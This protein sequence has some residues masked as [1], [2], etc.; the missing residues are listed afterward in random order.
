MRGLKSEICWEGQ[1]FW[2]HG[3]YRELNERA[4]L[5]DGS[6]PEEEAAC[7]PHVYR[8]IR[9]AFNGPE[10]CGAIPEGTESAPGCPAGCP[11]E[12][13]EAPGGPVTVYIAPGVYWIDDPGATDLMRK[14]PGDLLPF[15]MQIRCG[16][17]NIEG[18]SGHSE[19]VVIAGNRGQSH[20][21]NGNYTMLHFQVEELC[22]S[23][24]TLGNY[25][26]VDLVYPLDPSL[27]YPKR[28]DTIT[29]AQL[30]IQQG[31]K[32]YAR[33]CRF[34]SRLNLSP[35]CG[36]ERALYESC[37]FESTDDALN[38]NAVY[39]G[40]DFDF[41][42]GRPIY[43]ARQTGDVFIDCL[44][45]SRLAGGDAE[46][47]QYLTKE[48]GPVALI[49]C[50]YESGEGVRLYWTKYPGTALKC[51]QYQVSQNGQPV[52]L[53]GEEAEETV[54][55]Q[56]KKALE[57]YILEQ[58]GRYSANVG[59]LLGGSDG[60]DPMGL[61]AWAESAGRVGIPTLLTL[62]AQPSVIS[63]GEEAVLSAQA[64][65]FSHEPCGDYEPC[66]NREPC[67][68]KARFSVSA[69]D[70]AY[71]T[72]RQEGDASCVVTGCNHG[73]EAR[74]VV[75]R[76]CTENGLEAAVAVTVEP[77][78]QPAP[79][80]LK[81]PC[82]RRDNG[83]LILEYELSSG[84]ADISD[85]S[86]YRCDSPEGGGAVLCGIS[87]RDRPLGAYRLTAADEGGYMK[88]VIRPRVK[89]S[90]EGEAADAFL[91][92]PVEE[93]EVDRNRLFTD[94]SELPDG[95]R[96]TAQ[97]GRWI[98]DRAKPED[99]E[100]DSENF[101]GWAADTGAPAWRYG[102]TGNG[103]V[104]EG[105][106]QGVQ[107]A[108]LR[109]TPV[110]EHSGGMSMTVKA[111]PAKTAG[112][113][114]GIAGQYMDFGIKFDTVR[115]TGYALRVIRVREASDAVAMALVEYRDGRSRYLT[116]RIL[117][118]CYLTGCTIR[119]SLEG[120]RLTAEAST[121]APQPACKLEKGYEQAVRLEAEVEK[122][123]YGGILFWHT[124]TP[125]TGGWQNTTMLHSVEAIYDSV[126]S[127][128]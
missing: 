60:W 79:A 108:R 38:G 110:R 33:D 82:I 100:P 122:N 121:T 83:K 86:W 54:Q 42:G 1:G 58:D 97:G 14:K 22:V 76:A 95:S 53:G 15:G 126:V 111:D 78:L 65:L 92:E 101:S 47:C 118:S 30:A 69:E 35:I 55:L 59:N 43:R 67:E 40:C 87:R 113:G 18:L 102:R 74:E 51:Y 68:E 89:G 52:T 48:G 66:G 125:G 120:K 88:A 56:G 32:L 10:V 7:R 34:V 26:S 23:G 41:Y 21:C 45:R 107:G 29:Q 11:Q 117:T 20:A 73:T 17:L 4:V 39:V 90:L 50:R 77:Y 6:L 37:H 93:G 123:P 25:C 8:E 36:A 75:I 28:T 3:R 96:E 106:Y 127:G 2:Y 49:G 57:A 80:F 44:F 31:E 98:F 71:V 84:E 12:D 81:A 105:L 63:F 94:F 9:Q 115:L 116:E 5:L 103:S 85:I 124:G 72:I 61:L 104:G 109:Y 13:C 119:V 70:G 46:S 99:L 16:A 128:N 64:F 24:I 62:T 27:N 91:A 114:F 112:Q 19:D